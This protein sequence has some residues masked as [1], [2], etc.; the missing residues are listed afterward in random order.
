VH[1][2][3]S[4]RHKEA[5]VGGV[6]SVYS[7]WVL[8]LAE[9]APA[10][11]AFS[12]KFRELRPEQKTGR[13]A[14]VYGDKPHVVGGW[15]CARRHGQRRGILGDAPGPQGQVREH[16]GSHRLRPGTKV[17]R[18]QF[19]VGNCLRWLLTPG[20]SRRVNAEASTRDEARRALHTVGR[21]SRQTPK[22]GGGRWAPAAAERSIA[23]TFQLAPPVGFLSGSNWAGLGADLTLFNPHHN[24][25]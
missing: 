15:G 24:S 10:M 23:A 20:A 16:M 11:S 21:T 12:S 4:L 5:R 2:G 9:C 17:T 19:L 1:I 25:S 8:G 6:S 3:A 22:R 7:A 13:R 18:H 14:S